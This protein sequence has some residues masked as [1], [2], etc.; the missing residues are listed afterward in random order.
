MLGWSGSSNRSPSSRLVQWTRSTRVLICWSPVLTSL[1]AHPLEQCRRSPGLRQP[2]NSRDINSST[3]LKSTDDVISSDESL[4]IGTRSIIRTHVP[5]PTFH[6]RGM[7][8]G[9]R[10]T[11]ISRGREQRNG[12]KG[13]SGPNESVE[14]PDMQQNAVGFAPWSSF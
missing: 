5:P 1:Q 4:F 6:T 10:E 13:D 2:I 12:S 7:G 9:D 14:E 11:L 3:I 8:G